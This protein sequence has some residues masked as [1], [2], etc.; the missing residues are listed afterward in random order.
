MVMYS[1]KLNEEEAKG[2][3]ADNGTTHSELAPTRASTERFHGSG[4]H[5]KDRW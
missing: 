1:K 4:L 2:Y 5:G 3:A